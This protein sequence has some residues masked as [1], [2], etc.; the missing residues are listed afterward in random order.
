[1]MRFINR[2]RSWLQGDKA[3]RVIP[4]A[5][6]QQNWKEEDIPRYPPFMKGLPVVPVE[7]ILQTQSELIQRIRQSVAVNNDGFYR[8]Y[9]P[10]I[11]RFC[12][13]AHLLPAS[14]S[15]HHRGAGGL[16]RHSLEVA[17]YALQAS[18]RILL[19]LGKMPSER[20][21]MEPRWQL[22]V[23]LGALCHDA[24][25]PATD[26]TV[27]S[28]DR[29]LIWKPIRES[30][31]TW[32]NRCGV[33]AYF[34]NWREGRARQHTAMSNLVA[35]RIIGTETLM[36]VEEGGLELVVWL[37]ESLN[38]NPSAVNP[39]HG[40]VNQADQASVERD[41]KTIGATMAGYDLGVPVERLLIDIMRRLV[42]EGIWQVNEP[43][44][45]VWK[46]AGET[47]VIWPAGGED[48]VRIIREEKIP[49]LARTA[50]GILDMLTERRLIQV[51]GD[52]QSIF[53]HIIPEV[54]KQKIPDIRLQA[55]RLNDD[56]Q[57]SA[58]PL[59]PIEG[60]VCGINDSIPSDSGAAEEARN[61]NDR[62]DTSELTKATENVISIPEP[63]AAINQD[64]VLSTKLPLSLTS[65]T[66]A[67][68]PPVPAVEPVSLDGEAGVILLQ[69]LQ[70]LGNGNR[71]WGRD[72]FLDE[73]GCLLI[74]W[75]EALRDF[76]ESA[77]TIL[78]AFSIRQW[79]V[80]D[81]VTPWKKVMEINR[82]G[83]A[84]KVIQLEH[85]ISQAFA[86]MAANSD[87]KNSAERESDQ[88][89]EERQAD[90]LPEKRK[91]AGRPESDAEFPS[92]DEIFGVLR[93]FTDSKPDKDGWSS[94]DRKRLT[95]EIRTA[96]FRCTVVFL[97]K[98]VREKPEQFAME[99][100]TFRWRT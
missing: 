56:S 53:W 55:I 28:G 68:I 18:E 44:A 37:M 25:K 38:S 13:Y 99:S 46:I 86:E 9:Y 45:R 90:E 41:L 72:V 61:D 70:S 39:L 12:D 32:A 69:L 51:N 3:G 30:L 2:I 88:S 58:Q 8:Y 1:M 49:G 34:L 17:L 100:T 85:G 79:L 7:K 52:Q 10:A 6:I 31:Y 26:L 14:Q 4:A 76:G 27:S 50:D 42:R 57:V 59:Q 40:I 60:I 43:G 87:K 16:F 64:S 5:S 47:Y 24:G 91:K 23:F 19:D 83:E 98:L 33:N 65:E 78:E 75:P 22:A 29:A 82:D 94:A 36:W 35:D 93:A 71:Q 96:G 54:L 97:N 92:V 80:I 62:K 74:R 66:T 81:S 20:R 11:S 15:H 21:E 89:A 67:V 48:M 63:D 73:D 95:R 77:K 84:V